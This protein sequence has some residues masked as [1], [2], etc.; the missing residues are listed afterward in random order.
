MTVE[1]AAGEG[2]DYFFDFGCDCVASYKIGVI[3]NGAEKS[4]GQEVLDK[5]LLDDIRVDL[6]V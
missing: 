1:R 2:I 4:F 5:H 6:W 3:K